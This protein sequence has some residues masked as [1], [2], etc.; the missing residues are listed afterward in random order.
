[1]A[2][3]SHWAGIKHKKGRAD[4]ERS[5]I[6]SKLS[7][8]ITVAAKLGDKDPDMNPRLRTAIQAAK[9]SNM[10]KDNIARAISKSEI[11]GDKNYENLRYEGF[12]PSNVAFIIETLTD[13][14]NRSAS[15]I[16]T[17]LQKNGGRLGESGSTTHMFNNCGI[18]QFEK[19]KI[20]EEEAFEIAINAG[21]KDCIN[22]KD[23]FEIITEKE[24]FYKIKTE[25]EKKINIFSYSAIEWRPINYIDLNKEQGDKIL[26][27]LSALEELDDVQNIFSNANLEKIEI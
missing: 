5:K 25:L 14:K 9:Q 17:V 22:Q 20:S 19:D 15:S 13:N 1:M 12:G 3:H 21:A 7:R 2:G 6:F 27:T 18:I 16:R 26:E 4:K 8:E 11:S 24:D 10:P 23:N